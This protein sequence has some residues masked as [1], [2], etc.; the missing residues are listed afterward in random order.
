MRQP[1]CATGPQ[2]LPG[3][4]RYRAEVESGPPMRAVMKSL[5]LVTFW[6]TPGT[7]RSERG[8][9]A[10]IS[11]SARWPMRSE[12]NSPAVDS[13]TCHPPPKAPWRRKSWAARR[14]PKTGNVS[15][16]VRV[17][18][19]SRLFSRRA[20]RYRNGPS[21]RRSCPSSLPKTLS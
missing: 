17:N 4:R 21:A 11:T 16:A 13:L 1:V 5:L 3:N 2:E 6:L 15:P 12:I 18:T 20:I 7:V 9:S 19:L 10:M 14:V 8:S